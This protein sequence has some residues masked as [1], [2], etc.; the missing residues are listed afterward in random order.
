MWKY[1]ALGLPSSVCPNQRLKLKLNL[2]YE[3]SE[4]REVA[5]GQF[6][7][8][9]FCPSLAKANR[10]CAVQSS[11]LAVRWHPHKAGG[12]LQFSIEAYKPPWDLHLYSVIVSNVGSDSYSLGYCIIDCSS[13]MR[14]HCID[15][16]VPPDSEL[17]HMWTAF[18]VSV[19]R[20]LAFFCS[21]QMPS[22]CLLVWLN[23]HCLQRGT[24]CSPVLRR[25]LWQKSMLWNWSA[26][27]LCGAIFFG[28]HQLPVVWVCSELVLLLSFIPKGPTCSHVCSF[29]PIEKITGA[30]HH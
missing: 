23:I 16:L 9:S 4:I 25:T 18:I 21:L 10:C 14:M 26:F 15:H 22:G 5:W 1:W 30:S 11:F 6:K 20:L 7:S 13:K 8:W 27:K 2:N 3:V 19:L 29:H 24:S 28:L 12:K 17:E